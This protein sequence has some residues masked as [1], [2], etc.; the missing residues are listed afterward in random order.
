MTICANLIT[1]GETDLATVYS[2]YI[3]PHPSSV[4]QFHKW[5]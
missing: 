4:Y 1:S 2:N 3:A 5:L